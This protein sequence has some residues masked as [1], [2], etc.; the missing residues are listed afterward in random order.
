MIFEV[1]LQI[2]FLALTLLIF[3]LSS[4]SHV[5]SGK[6]VKVGSG[7]DLDYFSRTYKLPEWSLKLANPNKLFMRGE[8]IF[9]PQN[10]GLMSHLSRLPASLSPTT[11]TGDYI[12]PVPAVKKVSSSFGKRWGRPH[13]GIDIPARVGTHVVSVQSGVVV[14]S[15]SDLGGYGNITVIAHP[16]G[17][18]SIYAHADKNYTVKGQQVHQGQVIATVG[19]TGRSTGPHLHFE[20]RYN[21]K[22]LNPQLFVK[23]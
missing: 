11:Q 5:E 7:Q 18:F 22:A 4:C 20:L 8:W 16:G 17:I 12:W 10:R 19:N 15:G 3:L 2:K 9:I 6:Y 1:Y 23:N 13:E 21:S 14:Y